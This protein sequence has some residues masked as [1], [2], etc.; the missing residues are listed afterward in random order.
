MAYLEE[1]IDF[2]RYKFFPLK[3]DL[4]TRKEIL[5]VRS[6]YQERDIVSTNRQKKHGGIPITRPLF[7][8]EA[9]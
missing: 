5:S 3:A 6:S 8:V 2:S 1:T 4:R 7:Y 9:K